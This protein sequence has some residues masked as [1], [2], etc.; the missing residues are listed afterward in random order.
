MYTVPAEIIHFS[1]KSFLFHCIT[2]FQAYYSQDG[3]APWGGG[4]HPALVL[5]QEKLDDFHPWARC[6][7]L[8]SGFGYIEVNSFHFQFA[9]SFYLKLMLNSVK[10]FLCIYLDDRMIFVFNLL[11]GNVAWIDFLFRYPSPLWTN[12]EVLKGKTSLVCVREW[13]ANLWRISIYIFS[14]VV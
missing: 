6:R 9:E 7:L 1:L 3:G 11:I 14:N 8:I 12:T 2:Q 5:C 13:L 4:T 10:S